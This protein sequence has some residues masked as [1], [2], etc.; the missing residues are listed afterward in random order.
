MGTWA[1]GCGD[2]DDLCNSVWVPTVIIAFILIFQ[3]FGFRVLVTFQILN[4]DFP[5]FY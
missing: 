3:N 5:V 2:G 4:E 1:A